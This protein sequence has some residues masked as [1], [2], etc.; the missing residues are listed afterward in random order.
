M[1]RTMSTLSSCILA[2]A[3]IATL[4]PVADARSS[5]AWGGNPLDGN[6]LSCY[7]ET[8]GAVRGIGFTPSCT[9]PGGSGPRWEVQLPVDAAKSYTVQFSSMQGGGNGGPCCTAYAVSSTGILS[10]SNT[11]C[12]TGSGMIQRA[13]LNPVSVPSGGYLFLACF[14]L[15]YTDSQVGSV[16][17]N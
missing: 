3:G 13:P 17:W 4:T 5:G 11:I 12:S 9:P 6:S 14:G 15:Y 2:F 10:G 1:V 16:S 7:A 8:G